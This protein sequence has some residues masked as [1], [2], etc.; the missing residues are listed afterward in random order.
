M[1]CCNFMSYKELHL[2]SYFETGLS[3]RVKFLYSH[4]MS[5]RSSWTVGLAQCYLNAAVS[6]HSSW[7]FWVRRSPEAWRGKL[8]LCYLTKGCLLEV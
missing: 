6:S 2:C 7:D 1:A 5:W 4:L 3:A 8:S